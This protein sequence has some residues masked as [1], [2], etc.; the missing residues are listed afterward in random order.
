MKQSADI[1]SLLVQ[2][3]VTAL[4]NLL[5]SSSRVVRLSYVMYQ[6]LEDR[7]Q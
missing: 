5:T 6:P 7:E 4:A 2:A 3:R 1:S